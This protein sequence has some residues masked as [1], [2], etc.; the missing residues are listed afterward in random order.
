MAAVIAFAVGTI[1]FLALLWFSARGAI[2]VCILEVHNGEMVV[3]QGAI[4]PR[5]LNDLRDVVRKP[6]VGRATI[7]VVRSRDHASV[8]ARGELD[9]AQHQQLRNIIGNVPIAKLINAK[10]KARKRGK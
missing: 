6:R 7:R 1:F 10:G 8:E 5:V 4:A 3:T 9:E 2:T